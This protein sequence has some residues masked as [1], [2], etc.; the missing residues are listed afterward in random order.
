MLDADLHGSQRILDLVGYLA[1][2]LAPGFLPFVLGKFPGAAV[3]VVDHL[4]VGAYQQTQL[5]IGLVVDMLGLVG[6]VH[7][8]H[9]A[10]DLFQ[11]LCDGVGNGHAYQNRC[12]DEEYVQVD[13]GR[14]NR[15]R[16]VFEIGL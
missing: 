4:V 11:R 15:R 16:V 1:G 13:D 8:K 14:N 7:L 9:I 12:Y 6:D 10:V 2:H 5:V 3:Q